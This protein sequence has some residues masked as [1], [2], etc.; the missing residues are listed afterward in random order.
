MVARQS[1]RSLPVLGFL[2]LGLVSV[3]LGACV[4]APSTARRPAPRSVAT[5]LEAGF[6]AEQVAQIEDN[7]GPLGQPTLDPAYEHGPTDFVIRRAYV[8]QHSQLDKIARWVCEHVTPEELSGSEPRRNPFAPD[9]QLQGKPRSELVDYR[10]SG[11]DRGH[12]APAGDQ[13]KSRA[14]KDATFFLSN[15]TPQVPKHNQQVWA[16]LEDLVRSWV[17]DGGLSEEYIVTGGFFFDPKEENPATADGLI[18]YS[19]IGPGAVAV[20]THYFKIV[21]TPNGN[22]SWRAVAF[23]L[24]NHAY[25]QPFDFASYVK[26]IDWIEERA[27]IDFFPDLDPIQA[28]QVEGQAGTLLVP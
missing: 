5:H 12:L 4:S 28:Q 20:P 24:E 10:G 9:P 19:T 17:D 14:D 16:K 13:T 25:P 22:D 1:R 18:E 7:C 3:V 21:L 2:C 26:P 15:M 23:V 6:T 27:G 11:F 8:L